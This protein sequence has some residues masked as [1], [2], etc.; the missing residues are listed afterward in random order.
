MTKRT[1]KI[2]EER[3]LPE[4]RSISVRKPS[5]H[6]VTVNRT[7]VE[8]CLAFFVK[9]NHYNSECQDYKTIDQRKKGAYKF[10][11]CVR[12]SRTGHQFKNCQMERNCYYCR[13]NHTSAF[14]ERFGIQPTD[15]SSNEKEERREGTQVSTFEVKSV[16]DQKTGE[17]LFPVVK[18][19][20]SN[21]VDEKTKKET[22]LFFDSGSQCLFI[23]NKLA[24]E[25]NLPV[26]RRKLLTVN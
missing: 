1:R 13:K 26:I 5:T 20:L 25:L 7:K 19:V 16:T 18:A 15:K 8:N 14:C 21:P 24:Q 10:G 11:L 2:D 3:R 22:H 23:S 17:A 4:I 6:K 12:C 9:G